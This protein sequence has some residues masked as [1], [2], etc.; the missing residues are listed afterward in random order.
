[1]KTRTLVLVE[2]QPERLTVFPDTAK[3]L[4]RATRLCKKL[5]ATAAKKDM[6]YMIRSPIRWASNTK[7]VMARHKRSRR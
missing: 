3:G 2:K 6:P 7:T 4:I 5:S 1:M